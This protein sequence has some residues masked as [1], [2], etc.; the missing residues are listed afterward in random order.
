MKNNF[1]FLFLL[2]CSIEPSLSQF[3]ILVDGN[4]KKLT[5]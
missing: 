3:I 5:F 4:I 2:H 1:L